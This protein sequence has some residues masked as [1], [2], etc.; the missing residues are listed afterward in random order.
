MAK[1]KKIEAN[2]V[3]L[4]AIKA[5]TVTHVSQQEAIDAGLNATPPLVEVNTAADQIVNGKAPVRLSAAGHAHIGA[6]AGADAPSASPYAVQTGIVL[7]PSKRGNRG[8]GAGYPGRQ[9]DRQRIKKLA[10][11]C[12]PGAGDLEVD[13]GGEVVE[14]VGP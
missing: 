11:R 3:L 5:G 13:A 8:G 1:P 6:T 10:H 9:I 2:T 4:N 14:R 12:H 7:P